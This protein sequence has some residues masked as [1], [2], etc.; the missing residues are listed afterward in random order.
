MS[1]IDDKRYVLEYIDRRTLLEQLAEEAAELKVC[2]AILQIE[3][4]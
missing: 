1:Y 4:H 3:M 2:Q